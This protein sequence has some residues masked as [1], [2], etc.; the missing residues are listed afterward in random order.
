MSCCH[1]ISIIVIGVDVCDPQ[2]LSTGTEMEIESPTMVIIGI[3]HVHNGGG[4]LRRRI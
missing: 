3:T 2:S 1:D 4:W